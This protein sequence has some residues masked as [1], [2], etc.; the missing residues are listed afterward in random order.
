MKS[1][2]GITLIAIVVT[3]IV[4]IILAAIG[5]STLTGNGGMIGQSKEAER[6]TE[7]SEE[8]EIIK[9][10]ET[11][12]AALDVYG[13]VTRGNLEE[14]LDANKGNRE[15]KLEANAEETEFK[16]TFTKGSKFHTEHYIYTEKVDRVESGTGSSEVKGEIV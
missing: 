2:K 15:Y 10:S 9:L 8:E 12:A 1:E 7:K 13:V 5:I 3:V 14:M 4:L 11:Q 16:I 6:E